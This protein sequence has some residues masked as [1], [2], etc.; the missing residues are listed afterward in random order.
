[1][2]KCIAKLE[3]VYMFDAYCSYNGTL[4]GTFVSIILRFF[5]SSRT[6]FPG[7]V[8]LLTNNRGFN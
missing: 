1:M 2:G 6:N 4:E 7:I 3:V 8:D 5:V